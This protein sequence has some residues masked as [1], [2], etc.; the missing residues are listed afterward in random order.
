MD[1]H[2]SNSYSYLSNMTQNIQ[3]EYLREATQN[4]LKDN[5]AKLATYKG[6]K[7]HHQYKGGL[8]VHIHSVTELVLKIAVDY[9]GSELVDTDV[10]IAGA[11][12]HDAGKLVDTDKY[13]KLLEHTTLGV[14]YVA[15]YFDELHVATEDKEYIERLRQQVE[16][17]ILT[18]MSI[19]KED[20]PNEIRTIEA[21]LIHMA[22][23]I[24]GYM[25]ALSTDSNKAVYGG[26]NM[27]SNFPRDLI[28][29][30]QL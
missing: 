7:K 14:R 17:C 22:D 30:I 8:M 1:N 5:T 3:N 16:H 11:I 26:F 4:F 18:H 20:G 10:L 21:F 2:I 23:S 27:K 24:D 6:S 9:Y 25:E 19:P 13:P 15:K 29:S 12:M 28:K